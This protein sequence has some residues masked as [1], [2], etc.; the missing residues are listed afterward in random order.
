MQ[1]RI[2]MI[3]LTDAGGAMQEMNSFLASHRVLEMEQHFHALERGAYW[4]FCVRYLQSANGGGASSK[5]KVDYR[6]VLEPEEFARF[7]K[8]REV[9]KVIAQS[10]AIPAYAIFTDEELASIAQLKEISFSSIQTVK[11]IGEK[12]AQKYGALLLES[13]KQHE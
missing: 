9:R 6:A 1:V 10:E 4:S 3:P 13:F 12:K 7:A 2:Y 11:G 5:L 8:L